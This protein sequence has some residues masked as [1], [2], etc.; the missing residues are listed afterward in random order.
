MISRRL[1]SAESQ[2]ARRLTPAT[3]RVERI[4]IRHH[5]V[6]ALLHGTKYLVEQVI[7]IHIIWFPFC[8]KL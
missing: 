6:A 2:P 4:V 3:E 1:F 8:V 7:E 5:L